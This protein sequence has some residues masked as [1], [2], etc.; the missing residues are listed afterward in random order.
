MASQ[1]FEPRSKVTWKEPIEKRRHK[2]PI[3]EQ[4]FIPRSDLKESKMLYEILRFQ[5]ERNGRKEERI[6]IGYDVIGKK[7]RVR[8][9]WTWGQFCPYYRNKDLKTSTATGGT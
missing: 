7:P 6:R 1:K 5:Y 2:S 8:N 9:K 3:D 4:W